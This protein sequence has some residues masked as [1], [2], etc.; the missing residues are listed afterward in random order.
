MQRLLFYIYMFARLFWNGNTIKANS[1]AVYKK[2]LTFWSLYL[3]I[4]W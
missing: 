3:N 4:I 1:E 2:N